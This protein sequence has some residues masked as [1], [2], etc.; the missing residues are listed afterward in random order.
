MGQIISIAR[1]ILETSGRANWTSTAGDMA[2]SAN[3]RVAMQSADKIVYENYTEQDKKGT[4]EALVQEVRLNTPLD[5]GVDDN[6]Q[7]RE[8]MIFEKRYEFEVVRFVNNVPPQDDNSIQ[9]GYEYTTEE[10]RLIQDV[11]PDGKG[12][13]LNLSIHAH[14]ALGRD[15]TIKAFIKNQDQEGKITKPVHNR[16]R[17]FARNQVRSELTD[18]IATTKGKGPSLINQN[19]T[20]LCGM[21]CIFYLLAQ[22]DPEGYK[23]LGLELHQTGVATYGQYK[24]EPDVDMYD[25]DPKSENYPAF[26]EYSDGTKI[27]PPEL[28]PFAD[29]ITLAST[30]STESSLGYEGQAGQDF[31]AIN[32]PSIMVKLKKELLGYGDVVDKTDYGMNPNSLDKSNWLTEMQEALNQGYKIS[33]LIDSDM[34]SDKPTYFM[35]LTRWHWITFE[36]DVALDAAND[37]YTFSYFCWGKL[38]KSRSFK[39]KVFNTNFYGYIKGK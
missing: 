15:L 32:Y 30:R 12:K 8:G 17:F 20:S 6:G 14:A 7:E 16:F 22:K 25:M 13:K 18:R 23:K 35:N 33:M 28:M 5:K 27:N 1:N 10:G 38:K 37:A 34:L 4:K 2:L 31:S 3:G 24:I 39:M 26:R 11:F 36:G 21:A 19:S 29:W 9:W